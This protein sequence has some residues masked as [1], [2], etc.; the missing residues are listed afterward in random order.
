MTAMMITMIM[1]ITTGTMT[2][3]HMMMIMTV[4]KHMMMTMTVM[5]HMMMTM[6]IM[7][8]MGHMMMTSKATTSQLLKT[9]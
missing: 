1:M 3:K 2:M 8:V 5:K 9:C 4:M 6:T 7:M